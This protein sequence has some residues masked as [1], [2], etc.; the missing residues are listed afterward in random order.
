MLMRQRAVAIDQTG[1]A[2]RDS[3]AQAV[4]VLSVSDGALLRVESLPLWLLPR[5]VGGEAPLEGALSQQRAAGTLGRSAVGGVG[6][7]QEQQE[8]HTQTQCPPHLGTAAAGAGVPPRL[9][10]AEHS[11]E[12]QAGREEKHRI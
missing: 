1:G 10:T 4:S 5:S 8:H 7:V 11:M 9:E 6:C 12:K 2:A 3:C